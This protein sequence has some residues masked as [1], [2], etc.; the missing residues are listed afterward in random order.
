MTTVDIYASKHYTVYGLS[1]SYSTA[2]ATSTGSNDFADYWTVGQW[3][4]GANYYVY[5]AFLKFDTSVIPKYAAIE[6]V[7]MSLAI[8]SDYSATNFNTHIVYYDWSGSDPIGAGNRET[9]F[10]GCLASGSYVDWGSS[11]GK[12]ED[13]P[14]ASTALN[15]TWINRSGST[16]FG[17]MSSRDENDDTPA[18]EEYLQFYPE[19]HATVARRPILRV[20]YQPVAGVM[21]FIS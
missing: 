2:R 15:R 11:S 4:N 18:G 1:T 10:D 13:T 20:T 14:Y 8:W 6:E 7:V 5:R 17:F 16:Y 9:V 21:C 12:S 19:T 3:K